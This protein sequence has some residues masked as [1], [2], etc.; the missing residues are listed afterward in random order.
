MNA[1]GQFNKEHFDKALENLDDIFDE[2]FA[3]QVEFEKNEKK[4]QT[5]SEFDINKVQNPNNY[6]YGVEKS[7]LL[8]RR[9]YDLRKKHQDLIIKLQL[10]DNKTGQKE[11]QEKINIKNA[12]EQEWDYLV[13]KYNNLLRY[14]KPLQ[15]K[16]QPKQQ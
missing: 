11:A 8:R 1:K 9:Q 12:V 3:V 15:P 13:H 7:L 5:S 14:Q 6:E 2:Y 16:Q 10:S 4:A